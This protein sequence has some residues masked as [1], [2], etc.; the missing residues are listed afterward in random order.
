VIDTREKLATY[1]DEIHAGRPLTV[2]SGGR[3]AV[4]LI[5]PREF[6]RLR[7]LQRIVAWFRTAG[8]DLATADEAAVA[9]FVR[10]F[11]GRASGAEAATGGVSKRCRPDG[12]ALLCLESGRYARGL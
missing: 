5:S 12:P 2:I 6:D 7:N 4:T 9:A 11:R 8:L 3:F 10:E 1:L